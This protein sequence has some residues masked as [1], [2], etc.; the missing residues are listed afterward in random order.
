MPH[1]T[2][3]TLPNVAPQAT[4]NPYVRYTTLPAQGG[5]SPSPYYYVPLTNAAISEDIYEVVGGPVVNDKT[6]YEAVNSDRNPP[7]YSDLYD[8]TA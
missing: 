5:H 1:Y 2:G 3:N 4:L 6:V 7:S 8:D